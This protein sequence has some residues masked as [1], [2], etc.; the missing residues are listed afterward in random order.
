MSHDI[1]YASWSWIRIRTIVTSVG[2]VDEIWK[3]L[4]QWCA[5]QFTKI[6]YSW[7]HIGFLVHKLGYHYN[8]VMVNHYFSTFVAGTGE[9]V[10]DLLK[11]DLPA[12]QVFQKFDGLIA[13]S[14]DA[15]WNQISKVRYLNNSYLELSEYDSSSFELF[16][17]QILTY[18]RDY[19]RQTWDL[20]V[21]VS[22]KQKL[23]YRMMFY[24]R[25]QPVSLSKNQLEMAERFISDGELVDRTHPGME[26]SALLRSE[27]KG[28]LGIRLTYHPDFKTILQ[29]GE[30]RPEIAEI[31]VRLSDPN[32]SEVV[33]DPFAGFGAIVAA[34]HGH[35]YSKI[36][37]SDVNE[38]KLSHL[39]SRFGSDRQILL[40]LGEAS[41]MN[42]IK[43]GSVDK[44]ITDPP[45]GNFDQSV[46]TAKLYPVILNEFKRVLTDSG[47]IILLAARNA[48]DSTEFQIMGKWDVLISGR[49]ASIY[50]LGQKL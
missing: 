26:I 19:G 42:W 43:S 32:A 46:D 45:W 41:D 50:K 35:P 30:L 6:S 7:R 5:C 22:G 9:I 18:L 10:E 44:I 1:A 17:Q 4:T 31:M 2:N 8:V 38:A 25:N 21:K 39:K 15:T 36:L 3:L 23:S 49:Q 27:G 40:R 48:I 37:A 28:Y 20:M 16:G 13:F 34:R 14:C 11:K 33:L 29:P 12:I 47:E 24:D